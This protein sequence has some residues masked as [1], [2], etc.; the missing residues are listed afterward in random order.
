VHSSRG[1]IEDEEVDEEKKEDCYDDN[2]H[3]DENEQDNNDKLGEQSNYAS[4]FSRICIGCGPKFAFYSTRPIW[5]DPNL[6]C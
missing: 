2:E 6:P 1:R 5:Y 4:N 3:N